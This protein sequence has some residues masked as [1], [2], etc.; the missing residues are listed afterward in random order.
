MGKDCRKKD[1]SQGK[2]MEH[3]DKVYHLL[4]RIDEKS[5]AASE[6]M[7][8]YRQRN[9]GLQL[10]IMVLGTIATLLAGSLAAR[11][12]IIFTAIDSWQFGCAIVAIF[13]GLTAISAGLQERLHISDHLANVAACAAHL[14]ALRYSLRNSTP[15]LRVIE[16]QYDWLLEHYQ[17]YLR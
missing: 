17:Y 2:G 12:E 10:T 8:F 15:D 1:D 6:K 4:K 14:S 9:Y 7:L 16:A 3:S 11:G 13:T 5:Q